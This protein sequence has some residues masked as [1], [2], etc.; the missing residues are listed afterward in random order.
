MKNN[1]EQLL[2]ILEEFD[3]DSINEVFDRFE[4]GKEIYRVIAND[5]ETDTEFTLFFR[6]TTKSKNFTNRHLFG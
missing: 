4:N 1:I 6:F 3:Q 2:G 5:K